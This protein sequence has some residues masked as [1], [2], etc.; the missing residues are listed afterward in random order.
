MAL[1]DASSYRAS[2]S[3]HSCRASPGSLTEIV[4]EGETLDL[5]ANT[6]GNEF[7]TPSGFGLLVGSGGQDGKSLD[8]NDGGQVP[9]R[10]SFTDGSSGVF[11]STVPVPE[12]ASL[13]LIAVGAGMLLG[14]SRRQSGR[15]R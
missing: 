15:P 13:G 10:L 6:G 4:R 11:E 9:Y 1:V 14:H 8:Y 3:S 7:R 5:G 2:R 12:P